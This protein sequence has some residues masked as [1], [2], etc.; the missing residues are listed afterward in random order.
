MTDQ[1]R[2][3]A[4]IAALNIEGEPDNAAWKR[5]CDALEGWSTDGLARTALP[6][7]QPIID[8]WDIER[9]APGEWLVACMADGDDPRLSLATA[10]T[11]LWHH[12]LSYDNIAALLGSPSLRN[13]TEL[14]LYRPPLNDAAFAALLHN[15][16]LSGVRRLTLQG[17]ALDASRV[18]ALA[19]AP[20]L[21]AL[22]DLHLADDPIGA[23]ALDALLRAPLCAALADLTL[24]DVGLDAESALALLALPAAQ[25]LGWLSLGGAGLGDE[26]VPALRAWGGLPR[27]HALHLDD[28]ALTGAGLEALCEGGA[29]ATLE[30]LSMK[31]CPLGPLASFPDTLASLE[32]LWLD[33]CQLGDA[34]VRALAAS[35]C[36]APIMASSFNHN[37][38]TPDGL[39]DLLDSPLMIGSQFFH[40]N[41]NPLGDAGAVVIAQAAG[42][43]EA[44]TL[45]LSRCGI[46]EEGVRALVASPHL[47]ALTH[48]F[49]GSI[50][51]AELATFHAIA[52]AA[53]FTA[54]II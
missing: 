28:N 37:G 44:W 43:S 42:M 19:A 2:E 31:G 8:T 34:G 30:S 4:L 39:R 49:F 29:L 6:L 7:A 10:L 15:P 21:R 32:T 22:D 24:D 16:A 27:L 26:H 52:A 48:L 33:G 53:G 12:R 5:V 47:G 46:G 11:T 40:F 50:D 41:D 45:H 14:S 38:I 3:A 35:A 1:D 17:C 25:A 9:T 18:H 36:T 51:D 20:H 54:T 13:L 23:A